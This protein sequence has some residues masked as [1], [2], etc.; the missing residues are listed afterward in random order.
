[1]LGLQHPLLRFAKL[2]SGRYTDMNGF[3]EYS[4]AFGIKMIYWSAFTICLC[5]LAFKSKQKSL[6]VFMSLAVLLL[7]TSGWKI[8]KEKRNRAGYAFCVDNDANTSK[9]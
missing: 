1:M 6:L 4:Q 9:Y 7:F 2:F 8:N 5:L 3:G